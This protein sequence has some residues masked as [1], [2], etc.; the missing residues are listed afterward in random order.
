M[1]VCVYMGVC[2]KGVIVS[3]AQVYY[4]SAVK[5]DINVGVEEDKVYWAV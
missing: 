5:L 3:L 2:T 4:P 1:Y